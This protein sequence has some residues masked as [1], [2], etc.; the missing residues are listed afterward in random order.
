MKHHITLSTLGF[1]F[2]FYGGLVVFPPFYASHE[3]NFKFAFQLFIQ[4]VLIG[5]GLLCLLYRQNELKFHSK[6]LMLKK[7][8]RHEFLIAIILFMIIFI[9]NFLVLPAYYI[10]GA[11]QFLWYLKWIAPLEIF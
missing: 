10:L 2:F 7:L 3:F 11:L 4:L 6:H 5:I 9:P 8:Y 1:Y